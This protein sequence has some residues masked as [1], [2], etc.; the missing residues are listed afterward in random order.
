MMSKME[1]TSITLSTLLLL[2]HVGRR[3]FSRIAPWY[4]VTLHNS[5]HTILTSLL[6]QLLLLVLD[7]IVKY[8]L[9]QPR[10]LVSHKELVSEYQ[11]PE[12]Q[13]PECQLPKC[14]LPKMS[15]LTM[16]TPKMSTFQLFI[17]LLGF[18]QFFL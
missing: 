6:C 4:H 13:L 3:V 10:K 12:C 14:Q 8:V 1:L 16:S 7:S 9:L 18:H 2:T 11:R 5:T 17:L 15:T